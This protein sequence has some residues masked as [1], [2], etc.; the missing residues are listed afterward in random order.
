MDTVARQLIFTAKA[1]RRCFETRLAAAGASL[2]TWVILRSIQGEPHPNQREL[3][4]RLHIEG[5]TLTRHLDRL[6]AEGL[7]VRRR[8]RSDRR[9]VRIEITPAGER[10]YRKLVDIAKRTEQLGLYGVSQ[11]DRVHLRRLLER[12][13]E[14]L[15]GEDAHAAG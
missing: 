10:T 1:L 5:P 3:A 6:E 12:I 15:E 4:S 9:A 13:H 2:P 14:N 8:D 11:K 7:I